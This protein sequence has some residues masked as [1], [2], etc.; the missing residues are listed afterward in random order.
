MPLGTS[1][2]D[3]DEESPP[4]WLDTTNDH[5]F[6]ASVRD[7]PDEEETSPL[8]LSMLYES[9]VR[10]VDDD[11]NKEENDEEIGKSHNT[12]EVD[13]NGHEDELRHGGSGEDEHGATSSKPVLSGR[14]GGWWKVVKDK[15]I[16]NKS[17][18]KKQSI[19]DVWSQYGAMDKKTEKEEEDDHHTF[20]TSSTAKDSIIQ[21]SSRP[22]KPRRSCCL[23]IFFVIEL[24]ALLSCLGL[25]L[26]QILPVVVMDVR[27]MEPVDLALK[28]YISLFSLLFM[29][30]EYDPPIPF[31]RKAAFLQAYLSRGFLYSFLGLTCL[32]E[33]YSERVVDMLAHPL[34]EF[35]IAWFS[36]FL[37][38]SAW[39]LSALGILYAI[40]GLFCMKRL[41]D[42]LYREDRQKW[43]AYREKQKD[44][45]EKNP[46]S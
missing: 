34:D 11:E 42:K 30:V 37:Q 6:A 26:S 18:K 29:I 4:A 35:H 32:E 41:R 17:K 38:I 44:Y 20:A 19:A 27:Q 2:T 14:G 36:L 40:M 9:G 13:D 31:I 46:F 23:R 8:V 1:A 28:A 22:K 7:N 3:K 43:K 5:V 24:Y 21:K 45:W 25:L 15:T 16:S 39:C 10:S 12:M 33:A